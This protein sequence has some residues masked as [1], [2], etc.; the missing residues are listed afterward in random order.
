MALEIGAALRS[1]VCSLPPT[2]TP[3]QR[4]RRANATALACVEHGH[5]L[6][7]LGV[8][9]VPQFGWVCDGFTGWSF[10]MPSVVIL[11]PA[12]HNQLPQNNE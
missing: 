1:A 10:Q 6:S 9:P 12:N 8:T 11:G 7:E 3:S 5:L 2:G 4:C